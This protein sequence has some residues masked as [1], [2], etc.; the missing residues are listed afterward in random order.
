MH[1]KNFLA[2]VSGGVWTIGFR[3]GVMFMANQNVT[4]MGFLKDGKLVS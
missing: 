2:K 3:N 4:W 1:G